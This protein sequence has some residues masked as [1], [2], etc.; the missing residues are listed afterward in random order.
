MRTLEDLG[1][2]PF[3]SFSVSPSFPLSSLPFNL[4]LCSTW[5]S[6]KKVALVS[7][8]QI[9][10]K[11]QLLEE[12]NAVQSKF[13]MQAFAARDPMW[14]QW[15]LRHGTL[16]VFESLLSCLSSTLCTPTHPP[17]KKRKN[18]REQKFPGLYQWPHLFWT[19]Q[20]PQFHVECGKEL[21]IA[22]PLINN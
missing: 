18:G 11:M 22:F 6:M 3:I 16:I 10:Q 15:V 2:F 4:F 8:R 9:S 5:E 17:P 7:M 20:S 1:L 12:L 14:Q 13:Q 19:Q 21:L